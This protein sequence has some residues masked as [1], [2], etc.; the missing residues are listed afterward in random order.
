[1]AAIILKGRDLI[2]LESLAGVR[3]TG[4]FLL[5]GPRFVMEPVY[6]RLIFNST[7]KVQLYG[8]F[9]F[10]NCP[11]TGLSALSDYRKKSKKSKATRTPR[12]KVIGVTF[13]STLIHSID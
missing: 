10:V 11:A 8:F 6:N 2:K 12:Q 13:C 1:M 4:V 3:W 9:S 5:R 7:V